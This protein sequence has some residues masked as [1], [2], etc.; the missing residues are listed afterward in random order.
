MRLLISSS[1]PPDRGSGINAAVNELCMALR[2]LDCELHY[3]SPPPAD[4]TWLEQNQIAHLP[5]DQHSDPG[6]AVRQILNYVREH[7]IDAAINNDNAYLQAAAPALPCPLLVV[8]HMDRTSVGALACHQ[9]EWTDHVV[10]ISS[11]MQLKF[12]RHFGV[13]IQKCP[14]VFNGV[15]DLASGARMTDRDDGP[16]RVVYAGGWSHNKGSEFIRKAVKRAPAAWKDVRLDWFGNVPSKVASSLE[17]Y[18]A[19]ELHGRVPRAEFLETLRQADVFLLPSHKEGCPMAL[20]EAM[21]LGVLPISSDGIGA[22]RWLVTSGVDGF[23]CHV[24]DF[25]RQLVEC[26]EFLKRHP[27]TLRDMQRAARARFERDLRSEDT[28]RAILDLASHPTVDRSTRPARIP[29]LRWHRP[30]RPDGLKSP[31]ID[32]FCIRFG[33][34]RRAGHLELSDG[35]IET[36]GR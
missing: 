22:M 10:A 14:I 30:L 29:L 4:P 15:S 32:R 13:P 16:L 23:T 8:G 36:E 20:I 12:A 17:K 31:L 2:S 1:S 21:S 9:H 19:V 26:I 35:P 28:A 7:D 25:D 6:D 18:A 33:L 5:L 34:L 11:D 24:T 27:D 3:T